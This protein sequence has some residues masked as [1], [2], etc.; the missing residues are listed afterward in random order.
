M[1]ESNLEQLFKEAIGMPWVRYVQ[2]Y[3]IQQAAALL[4]ENQCNVTEAA[5][6]V[7]FN[8]LSH[9]NAAFRTNMGLSPSQ[10]AKQV[11]K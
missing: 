11:R 7:G 5:L 1:S 2:R 10:Y 9:F 3:R 8:S 6:A 4:V